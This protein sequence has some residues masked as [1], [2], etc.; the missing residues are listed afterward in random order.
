MNTLWHFPADLLL[1][2][3]VIGGSLPAD[4][5]QTQH[6]VYS[7]INDHH[8]GFRIFFEQCVYYFLII[9]D[10]SDDHSYFPPRQENTSLPFLIQ[11]YTKVSDE[12][13]SKYKTDYKVARNQI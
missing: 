5:E 9:R 7:K 3:R 6:V 8:V 2:T 11:K 10:N 1:L 4:L 12:C 13:H